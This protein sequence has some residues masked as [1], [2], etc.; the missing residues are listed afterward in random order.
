M[1][2]SPELERQYPHYAGS[3]SLRNFDGSKG[4]LRVTE[5]PHEY[6]ARR[7]VYNGVSET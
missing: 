2:M 4:S 3:S 1:F 5:M 6:R 7:R